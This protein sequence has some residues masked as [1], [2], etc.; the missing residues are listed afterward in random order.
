MAVIDE[1][2][3]EIELEYD[4]V[5]SAGA[6]AAPVGLMARA[7]SVLDMA[8][9][10]MRAAPLV[11]L[12]VASVAGFAALGDL[13]GF[14]VGMIAYPDLFA[15]TIGG[16]ATSEVNGALLQVLSLMAL[17]AVAGVVG[18]V[19]VFWKRRLGWGLLAAFGV[20]QVIRSWVVYT[21]M[22]SAFDFPPG[23]ASSWWALQ[24]LGDWTRM[25]IAAAFLGL[26]FVPSVLRWAFAKP[27][28]GADGRL[29]DASAEVAAVSPS[30]PW[31]V[32]SRAL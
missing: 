10:R 2:E 23:V 27:D 7:R 6:S 3:L 31:S 24:D 4:T 20:W 18:A 22:F 8:A 16:A 32:G 30:R 13:V 15:E 11:M 5:P 25:A 19:A 14:I 12:F 26:L 17:A 1:Y 9:G 28:G 21:L 29:A